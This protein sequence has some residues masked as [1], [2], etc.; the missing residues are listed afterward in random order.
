ML[1]VKVFDSV[2]LPAADRFDA[3]QQLLGQAHA[4]LY[5]TS[6]FAADFQGTLRQFYLG[7]VE[8]WS[9]TFPHLAFHRTP[10]LIRQSDP[11]HC[12]LAL[13]LQGEGLVR[14]GRTE[15]ALGRYDFH[16]NHT[17]VPFDITTRHGPV[18]IIGV[19]LPRASLGLPWGRVQ[20]V[21]G[22][23]LSGRDG[24]G[25][26]LRQFL[27]QVTRDT[28]VY[29]PSE[30]PR[31]GRVLS[32]LVTA[33][34]AQALDAEERLQP[35]TRTHALALQVKAFIRRNVSD[36]D[37]TPG[38]VAAA[39][40]ISRSHLHRL[41]QSADTTVAAYIRAQRLEAARADLADATAVPIHAIAARYGFKDHT[42]FTR[43]F[44]DAYGTTPREYRQ[45]AHMPPVA[46]E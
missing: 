43:S 13:L 45:A 10:G 9:A 31:L 44:R 20:E 46:E 26:L 41:F 42:T 5:L 21:V 3:F 24:L 30:A 16:A 37:L 33:L 23:D 4:P 15:R 17:S 29:Q 11:E 34:F 28:G 18:A 1:D 22:L 12:S 35:E 7:G 14:W 2:D 8:L 38:K 40:H 19:E 39:H 36:P 6:D 32:E 25:A 27:T